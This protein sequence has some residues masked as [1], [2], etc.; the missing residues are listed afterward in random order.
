MDINEIWVDCFGYEK[1]YQVSSL[2][3]VKR[4]ERYSYSK[5]TKSIVYY[6]EKISNFRIKKGYINVSLYDRKNQKEFLIHRL[7]ALSF[8]LKKLSYEIEV[9]HIN[10]IKTDNKIENL[11]WVTSRGNSTH[12][13]NKKNEKKCVGVYY[14]KKQNKWYSII[15]INNKNKWL[16]TFNTEKDAEIAYN[17]AITLNP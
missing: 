3:R 12:Y 14:R 8:K 1:L 11:E 9:N 16:G 6:K 2:G 7:I 15:S 17:K 4:I 13:F 10:G 5:A